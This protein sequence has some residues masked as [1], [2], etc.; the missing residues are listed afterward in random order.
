MIAEYWTEESEGRNDCRSEFKGA[1]NCF[2]KFDPNNL[3]MSV[4]DPV[5]CRM[6]AGPN[7]MASG[8]IIATMYREQNWPK[9]KIAPYQVQL[10]KTERV[11]WGFPKDLPPS[12]FRVY[13]LWDDDYH[14]RRPIGVACSLLQNESCEC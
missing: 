14:I 12:L 13:T 5:E 8:V 9:V 1:D 11:R 4:G 7:D 3:R 2:Q 6:G 10:N